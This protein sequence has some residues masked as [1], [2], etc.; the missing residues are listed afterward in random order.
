M[1]CG[2]R[3]SGSMPSTAPPSAT[4][5]SKANLRRRHLL[6]DICTVADQCTEELKS[7][8][9]KILLPC[10]RKK[11]WDIWGTYELATAE[12]KKKLEEIVVSKGKEPSGEF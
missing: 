9:V 4:T 10:A 11:M 5:N 7:E 1:L 6:Q 2:V 8:E 3:G 12:E